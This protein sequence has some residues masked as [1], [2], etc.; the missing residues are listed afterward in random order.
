MISQPV[1]RSFFKKILPFIGLGVLILAA[2]S[3]SLLGSFTSLDDTANITHNTFLLNKNYAGIWTHSI[4]GMYIPL[5]YSFWGIILQ[6]FGENALVFHLFNLFLH[7]FNSGLVFY[8]VKKLTS[9]WLSSA[10]SNQQS[11]IAFLT[12]V[13]FALHP[14]QVE[15]VAWLTGG[16]DLMAASLALMR[17]V[18]IWG[19]GIILGSF[20]FLFSQ[21]F[22]NRA[23][24]VSRFYSGVPTSS[25]E[26]I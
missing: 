17:H 3:T 2:Y 13:I 12:A 22:V 8:L 23:L 18:C 25:K 1:E 5:A 21:C 14:L 11:Q 24:P 6:L 15:T 7:L 10:S 26:K 4:L 19:R 9:K 16:R 20:S